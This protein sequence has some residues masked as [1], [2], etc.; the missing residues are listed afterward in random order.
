MT[1]ILSDSVPKTMINALYRY[2]EQPKN[3]MTVGE[4]Y[5]LLKLI[6]SKLEDEIE[7]IGEDTQQLNFTE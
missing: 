3:S 5:L 2:Y 7:K 4:L 6:V 1:F